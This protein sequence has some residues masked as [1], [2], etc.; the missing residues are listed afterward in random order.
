M[1]ESVEKNAKLAYLRLL[2]AVS[3]IEDQ[4]EDQN[5][6]ISG[7]MKKRRKRDI[8]DK[9]IKVKELSEQ[10]YSD[11]QIAKKMGISRDSVRLFVQYLKEDDD[12]D[13]T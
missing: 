7:N 11:Q 13:N 8:P 3:K 4:N 10:G 1:Q 2:Q 12:E 5:E 9:Y 6:I